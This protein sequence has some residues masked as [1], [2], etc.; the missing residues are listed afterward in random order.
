MKK[1][2]YASDYLCKK[3]RLGALYYNYIK[4][5]YKGDTNIT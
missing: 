3:K 1:C 4:T 5:D 2:S